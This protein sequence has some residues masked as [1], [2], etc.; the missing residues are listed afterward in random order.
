MRLLALDFGSVNIGVAV[1][2]P[3][4]LTAQG[5]GTIRRRSHA[6]DMAE[7]KALVEEYQPRA[8]VLGLP[9]NMDGSRG[10]AVYRVQS[11]G[12]LLKQQFNLPV[13]YQDERL[14]TV[15]AQKT[16]LNNDTSR[17]KRRQV[18]DKLA[19]TLILSTYLENP[20]NIK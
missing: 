13:Y 5:V 19:A 18:V 6:Q 7:L 9:L 16:L 14:T 20:N 8:F 17:Q 12:S 3:L 11:F 2:D 1:S 4:G 15:A 10:L